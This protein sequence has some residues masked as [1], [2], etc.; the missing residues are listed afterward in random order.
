MRIAVDAMG[1]DYA[2]REVVRGAL[3]VAAD[4]Q[5]S[6]EIILV[7][8]QPQIEAEFH[9]FGLKIPQAIRIVHASEQIEMHEHPAQAMKR[10][11]DSSLVV[12]AKLV[13][14]GD[15]E[16]T[17]SAGNT[18]A[19]MAIALYDIGRIPG[20][21]RP[22]IATLVPTPHGPVLLLDAGAMM[23]CSPQNL[24]QFA[25]LGS[26]YASKVLRI[27]N[28]SIGLLNV[29]SEP[30][31]GNELTKA[32]F[33]LLSAGKL[34]FYGNVEGKDI[35]E[36]VTDVVVCD[37]FAGNVVLKAVEGTIEAFVSMMA[38][39][40]EAV[41]GTET[42]SAEMTVISSILKKFDYAETGG[43]PLLGINGVT[44]IGHGR[45]KARAIENAIKTTLAAASSDYV[46]AVREAV[47][48]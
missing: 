8:N 11:R 20:I 25:I 16:G 24:K 15:A 5:F 6:D 36:R 27:P 18:G 12:C 39:A 13:K 17:F 42:A 19:T 3:D 23:D 14:Q 7:G 40:A 9:H 2:P 22:A 1:G 41:G 4:P 43:A 10:K 31:K 38:S 32:A 33:D 44:F 45:S 30:G 28:P 48:Q 26:V 34:N 46:S 35:F 29:G 21:D 47:T 37:G